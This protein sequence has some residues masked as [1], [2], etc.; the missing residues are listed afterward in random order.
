MCE[1]AHPCLPIPSATRVA[2]PPLQGARRRPPP[3]GRRCGADRR[4]HCAF[5]V[6]VVLGQRQDRKLAAH[7]VGDDRAR[8]CRY[9][10]TI[11]RIVNSVFFSHYVI[12]QHGKLKLLTSWFALSGFMV[13]VFIAPCSTLYLQQFSNDGGAIADLDAARLFN[14]QFKQTITLHHATFVV[15]TDGAFLSQSTCRIFS[16]HSAILVEATIG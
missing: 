12:T 13:Y 7:A 5:S 8:R 4:C 3:R 16:D 14:V 15:H 11:G 9:A 10:W 1:Q 2:S 6:H